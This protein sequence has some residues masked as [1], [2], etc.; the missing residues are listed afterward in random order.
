MPLSVTTGILY[1]LHGF[2]SVKNWEWDSETD[3]QESSLASFHFGDKTPFVFLLHIKAAAL[4]MFLVPG[5]MSLASSM[6]TSTTASL[7]NPQISSDEPEGE[8]FAY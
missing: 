2:M 8:D 1:P 6:Y 5:P 3:P 4:Q 7:P